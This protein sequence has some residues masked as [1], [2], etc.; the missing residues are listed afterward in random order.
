MCRTASVLAC[1]FCLVKYSLFTAHH[2]LRQ[3]VD[4]TLR[5]FLGRHFRFPASFRSVR[6]FIPAQWHYFP[7]TKPAMEPKDYPNFDDL[8]KV[9]GFPQGCAW[10]IFDQ[11]G[12][13]DVYGTLNFLTAKVVQAAAAEVKDGISIS[14]KYVLRQRLL[15][16]QRYR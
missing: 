13:K 15:P 8:P 7:C 3:R 11:D 2:A 14:L 16:S 9:E 1:A 5:L 12:K 4:L 6:P 10:G